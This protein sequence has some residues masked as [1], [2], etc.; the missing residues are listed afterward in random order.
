MYS[1]GVPRYDVQRGGKSVGHVLVQDDHEVPGGSVVENLYVDPAHRRQGLARELL[2]QVKAN[3]KGPLR[4][5]P[6]PHS[7]MPVDIEGLKGLYA[8][9]GFKPTGDA[10]DNMVL[11][12]LAFDSCITRLTKAAALDESEKNLFRQVLDQQQKFDQLASSG[13]MTDAQKE[14]HRANTERLQLFMAKRKNDKAKIPTWAKDPL[15]TK[16]G[17]TTARAVG[18]RPPPPGQSAH[19]RAPMGPM[20][21]FVSKHPYA[22]AAGAGALYGGAAGGVVQAMRSKEEK[23]QAIEEGRKAGPISEFAAKHP[24]AATAAYM[25]ASLPSIVYGGRKGGMLGSIAGAYAPGLA[26]SALQ[27]G[28]NK[29]RGGTPAELDNKE[30]RNRRRREEY[31]RKASTPHT[32]KPKSGPA[33]ARPA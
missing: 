5:R 28:I 18:G 1:G 13:K 17:G 11:D 7:D 22:A 15:G 30:E 29:V 8:S 25:G 23:T 10:R 16:P 24:A 12:K 9:E 33:V 26:I 32:P 3:Q 31:A 4:I 27:H 14:A 20:M 2:G 19:Y 21:S 6:R